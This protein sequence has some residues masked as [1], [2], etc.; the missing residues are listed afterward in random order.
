MTSRITEL[1]VDCADPAA[2]ARFWAAVL[3]YAVLDEEPDLVEIG[4]AGRVDEQLLAEV[5]TGPV[6]PTIFFARV[7]EEKVVKNRLHLD[8]SPVDTDRDTEV[9][10]LEALGARRTDLAPTD[11]T[12]V[13][14]LDPEGNEFCVLRSLA[15][16]RFAL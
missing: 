10:R 3:D 15:P 1:S 7:P 8:L 13:V 5:R 2:L 14:M 11:S 12:W 4:P 16:G 6:T 9:A